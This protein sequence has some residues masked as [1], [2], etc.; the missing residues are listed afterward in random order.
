MLWQCDTE[1][2]V[3]YIGWINIKEKKKNPRYI[4]VVTNNIPNHD[5]EIESPK[6]TYRA[7]VGFS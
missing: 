1:R 5:K 2:K 4:A 7:D 3:S 6:R